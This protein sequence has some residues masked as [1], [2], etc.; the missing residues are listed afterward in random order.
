MKLTNKIRPNKKLVNIV[1]K[2]FRLS[3]LIP[4]VVNIFGFFIA[5]IIL[6]IVSREKIKKKKIQPIKNHQVL[7]FFTFL[8]FFVGGF[9]FLEEE[10]L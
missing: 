10:G 2:L 9:V 7:I 5:S 8:T 1:K 6:T 4:K 3:D